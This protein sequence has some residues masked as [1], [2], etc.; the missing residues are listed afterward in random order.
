MTDESFT[1][2][3]GAGGFIG[4][5]LCREL[6]RRN[7]RFIGILSPTGQEPRLGNEPW[8]AGS[9]RSMDLQD[10][11]AIEG[12]FADVT[13]SRIFNLA[14]VGTHPNARWDPT[15]YVDVNVRVPVLLGQLMPRRCTL[16]QVGSMSQYASSTEP[17]DED[18]ARRDCST[19]YGWSKN[20]ADSLLE[21]VARADR[22]DA[23]A[24]V[25]V[26]LF[27]VVGAGEPAHRLI[28]SVVRGWIDS[29]DV[30][31][32]DGDQVR[33]VLHVDDAVA[34]LLHVGDHSSMIG[35]AVNVGRGEGRSVRWIAERAADRLRCREHLRFGAIPR[36]TYEA[37]QL[38]ADTSRLRTTGWRPRW[39]FEESID[40]AVDDMVALRSRV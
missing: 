2:V 18:A 22:G 28:P 27:G 3:T 1:L 23:A 8:P 16:V 15:A 13:F 10:A 34:A 38:V 37:S 4:S 5:H 26:R 29:A 21:A 31:L 6:A 20:A 39:T 32:S 12:L 7:E 24:V 19:L 17:L 25:R 33:D 40:R 9:L 35:R 30:P 36:R 14:A 11:R